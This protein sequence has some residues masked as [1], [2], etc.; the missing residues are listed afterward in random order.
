LLLQ[1]L[2]GINCLNP[3]FLTYSHPLTDLSGKTVMEWEVF[4]GGVNKEFTMRL[5]L[6]GKLGFFS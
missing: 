5:K 6:L 1:P 2:G 3:D 4:L